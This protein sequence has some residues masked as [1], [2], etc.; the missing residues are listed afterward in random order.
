METSHVFSGL[1]GFS[2]L[3]AVQSL[4]AGYAASRR[5]ET[6]QAIE[7]YSVWIDGPTPGGA[8]QNVVY[9][10]ASSRGVSPHKINQGD[11]DPLPHNI[12]TWVDPW[13]NQ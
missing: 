13:D 5:L 6:A 7:R 3:E 8:L 1:Q 2:G 10:Q 9:A 11:E 4:R 12:P